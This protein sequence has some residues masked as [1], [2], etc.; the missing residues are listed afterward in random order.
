MYVRPSP[1]G[2]PRA[3]IILCTTRA[4]SYATC[5]AS[6]D[7]QTEVNYELITLDEIGPLARIRNQGLRAAT[8]PVV[9][10]I[11]D[12][13]VVPP[14]WLR[15]VLAGF[16]RGPR[17]VGVSGPAIIPLAA[18]HH[19]DLF[20]YR[21]LLQLYRCLFLDGDHQP[22]SISRA[23]A[24]ATSSAD[25]DCNYEGVVDY[26]E[27]CNMSFRRD[28][29]NAVGGFDEAYRDLGEWCE[30]DLCYRL[31]AADPTVQCYFTPTAALI[32]RPALGAA[33]LRRRQTR[34]RLAN[35]RL[36]ARRWVRPCWQHTLYTA[37]MGTYYASLE[38]RRAL[39][40]AP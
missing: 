19:R 26:L 22:G 38:C 1:T 13:T 2:A 5:V 24:A 6:L 4:D 8:A 32:H 25:E 21:Q 35:Y 3:S 37:F 28:A 10:F 17:I 36:F 23:G 9:C 16:E 11:D 15:G 34:S 7:A 18:R 33:T 20:R 12:D 39:S 14:T 29:L 40:Y 31:R 27:A 30:P